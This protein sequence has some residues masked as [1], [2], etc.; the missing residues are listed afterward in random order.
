MNL[1]N[2][3]SIG[4]FSLL[5]F[6][7]TTTIQVPNNKPPELPVNEAKLSEVNQLKA[8][9]FKA[10]TQLTQCRVDLL[11]RESRLASSNLTSEQS[12]LELEFRKDLKCKETDKF[13]WVTLK[14]EPPK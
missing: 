14:C 5:M 12:K 6:L 1:L 8:E 11:D 2:K 3:H 9:L 4:I 7:T 10:R 13:N